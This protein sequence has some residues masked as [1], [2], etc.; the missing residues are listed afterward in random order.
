MRNIDVKIKKCALGEYIED[1]S[2]NNIKIIDTKKGNNNIIASNISIFPKILQII[3]L[4]ITYLPMLKY[5][6]G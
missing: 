5:L 4:F 1:F 6:P 3:F 2:K